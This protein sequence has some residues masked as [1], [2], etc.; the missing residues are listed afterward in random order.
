MK[1]LKGDIITILK[2]DPIGGWW[3]GELNGRVGS[4]PSNYVAE[5]PN[6]VEAPTSKQATPAK[7]QTPPS[8]QPQPKSVTPQ[9]QPVKASVVP[10]RTTIAQPSSGPQPRLPL[11]L[12]PQN[13]RPA[14][15]SQ[16][17][18]S[19]SLPN[20]LTRPLSPPPT[21]PAPVRSNPSTG[22]ILLRL[23]LTL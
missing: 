22:S 17:N 6:S 4:F 10:Q 7:F 8:S 5:L 14:P 3:D 23:I 9:L 19:H 20:T 11:H 18:T 16:E 13:V 12:Q 15:Q 1:F 21:R 2:K